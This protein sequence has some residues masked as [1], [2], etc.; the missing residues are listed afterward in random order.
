MNEHRITIFLGG[1]VILLGVG[2]IP[3]ILGAL[4]RMTGG[5]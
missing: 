5:E 2:A 3:L 1:L 4:A